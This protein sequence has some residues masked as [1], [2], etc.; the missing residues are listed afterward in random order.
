MSAHL[1]AA[2]CGGCLQVIDFKRCGG[3]RR[4]NAAAAAVARTLLKTLVRRFC[5]GLRGFPPIPPYI[6]MAPFEG[7]TWVLETRVISLP[8]IASSPHQCRAH[9]PIPLL[10]YRV[11]P[12]S[13]AFFA[14]RLDSGR[15]RAG[16]SKNL[17]LAGPNARGIC[18]ATAFKKTFRF[19]PA[20]SP[21]IDHTLCAA[22]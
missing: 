13:N 19:R 7:G 10:P 21:S 9:T 15:G 1:N 18:L 5:G 4:F 8:N 11:F 6:P 22:R 16:P 3:L 2:V 12:P 17:S 20:T 14:L